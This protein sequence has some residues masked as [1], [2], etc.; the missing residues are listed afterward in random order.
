LAAFC[1]SGY[2]KPVEPVIRGPSVRILVR[3]PD[4]RTAESPHKGLFHY[5]HGAVRDRNQQTAGP[6]NG[7]PR[8]EAAQRRATAALREALAQEGNEGATPAR[9]A[10][11]SGCPAS[12]HRVGI[13]AKLV[14]SGALPYNL[15]SDLSAH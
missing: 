2:E 14:G 1:L 9:P 8:A 7:S 13:H 15:L 10:Q 5:T 4:G 12:Y 11:S 6:R 3:L